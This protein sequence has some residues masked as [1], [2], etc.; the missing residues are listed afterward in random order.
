MESFT[1]DSFDDLITELS[2]G[3]CSLPL[4]L[5]EADRRGCSGVVLCNR[6]ALHVARSYRSGIVN[7]DDCDSVMNAL[8]GIACTPASPMFESV[9]S[10]VWFAVY[11]AFDEGEYQHPGDGSDVVPADKYTKPRVEKILASND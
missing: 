10:E 4:L 5:L 3:K 1:L 9:S 2:R 7:F 6:L 8:F 11:Q